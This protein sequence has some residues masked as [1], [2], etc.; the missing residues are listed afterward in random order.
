MRPALLHSSSDEEAND[1]KKTEN[2]GETAEMRKLAARATVRLSPFTTSTF[3]IIGSWVT[4]PTK[5]HGRLAVGA[6]GSSF[7][8]T[9][10]K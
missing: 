4:G 6:A 2:V 7:G 1:E 9:T 5:R 3:R 8:D 10:V